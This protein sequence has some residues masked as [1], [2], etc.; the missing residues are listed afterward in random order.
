MTKQQITKGNFLYREGD[1]AENV[2]IIVNGEIEVTKN[3]L[4]TRPGLRLID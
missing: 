2:Y 3:I 4:N 1:K